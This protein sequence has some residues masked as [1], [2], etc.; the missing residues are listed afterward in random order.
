MRTQLQ[1][2]VLTFCSR[3]RIASGREI[4]GHAGQNWIFSRSSKRAKFFFKPH[5]PESPISVGCLSNGHNKERP[6]RG[7]LVKHWWQQVCPQNSSRGTFSPW[8]RNTSLQTLHSRIV[9]S[10]QNYFILIFIWNQLNDNI[11]IYIHIYHVWKHA[12]SYSKFIYKIIT[13]IFYLNFLLNNCLQWTGK[14]CAHAEYYK[15]LLIIN[16]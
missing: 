6:C 5:T 7:S 3:V 1:I 13:Y 14:L 10:R 15:W 2:K 11:Y 4:V 16:S 9:W 8:K 12:A